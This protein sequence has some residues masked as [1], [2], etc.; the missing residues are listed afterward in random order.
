MGLG[1]TLALWQVTWTHGRARSVDLGLWP[2]GAGEAVQCPIDHPVER[3]ASALFPGEQPGVNKQLEVMGHRRLRQ[4]DRFGEVAYTSLGAL[5]RGDERHEPNPRG[6]TKSFEDL[7]E[8][9]GLSLFEDATGDGAA[10]GS[11]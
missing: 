2:E 7:R 9:L 1:E 4:P 11:S 10:A 5:M 8:S 3:P 6:I